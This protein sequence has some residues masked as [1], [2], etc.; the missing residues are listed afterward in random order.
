MV[1]VTKSMSSRENHICLIPNCLHS[2][3]LRYEDKPEREH[4]G[5][6]CLDAQN[7]HAEREGGLAANQ[8][9]FRTSRSRRC[10]EVVIWLEAR[11][12]A[13]CYRLFVSP[14]QIHMLKFTRD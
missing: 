5:L 8:R 1:R 14:L 13:L 7:F 2:F 12:G 6:C 9:R 10:S 3:P 11:L 4:E